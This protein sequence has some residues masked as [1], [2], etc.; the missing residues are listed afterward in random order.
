MWVGV[1]KSGSPISRWTTSLPCRSSALARARTSNADSVPSRLMRSATF[2]PCL[3]VEWSVIIAL[4]DWVEVA[5]GPVTM[6]WAGG[7]PA[8]RPPARPLQSAAPRRLDA[9]Q[10]AGAA[11]PLGRLPRVVCRLVRRGLLRGVA[12]AQS[13][14]PRPRH[15][16]REP[17]WGLAARRPLE[18][19]GP[20]LVAAAGAAL[21]RLRSTA[22]PQRLKTG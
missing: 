19:G 12:G 9:G 8:E 7:H 20:P 21:L 22:C 2:M 10:S 18:P 13:P 16:P 1:S 6:G 14:R 15:P 4:V 11:R 5:A 17:R 3:L